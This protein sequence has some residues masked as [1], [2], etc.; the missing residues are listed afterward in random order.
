VH[1]L[2]FAC[3]VEQVEVFLRRHRDLACVLTEPLVGR[4][5]VL[6]PPVGWLSSLARVCRDHEVLLIVDEVFTGFG[7]TGNWFVSAAEEV[8]PD[9]LCCG[10]ALAG[11]LPIGAVIARRQ[12]FSSW[13]T[14]GEALH[15]GT[16]VANPL[17]CA[18]GLAVLRVL[19]SDRLPQRARELGHSVEQRIGDWPDRF[20]V[21]TGVRGRGLLW[22]L[23]FA[24]PTLAGRVSRHLLRQGVIA[25]AG[26]PH[27]SV[28]QLVPPLVI[29]ERQLT[30]S[31]DILES[32]LARLAGEESG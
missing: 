8:E 31:L 9:L 25:L 19:A 21:L 14:R 20:T 13:Q 28:L 16:F 17:S 26:G 6:V 1:R 30:R 7:R 15:T 22:G 5:G 3:P 18:A 4:E 32:T 12:V 24:G 27:G 23:E 11:G 10:K 29:S 2:P